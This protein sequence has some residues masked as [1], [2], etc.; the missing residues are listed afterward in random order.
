MDSAP[1]PSRF[2]RDRLSPLKQ[3]RV[4]VVVNQTVPPLYT[5][6]RGNPARSEGRRRVHE[7]N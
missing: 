5:V 2:R 4:H 6:E 3:R 7:F 1:C